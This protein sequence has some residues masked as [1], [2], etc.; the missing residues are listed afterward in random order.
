M[1]SKDDWLPRGMTRADLEAA[2]RAHAEERARLPCVGAGTREERAAR[3]EA[4]GAHKGCSYREAAGGRVVMD[5]DPDCPR[6]R[7]IRAWR[8]RG[9][10]APARLKAT[11]LA[12]L[13]G[14]YDENEDRLLPPVP[15]LETDALKV[16][17]AW[18][19]GKPARV[20][21]A[22]GAAVDVRGDEWCLVLAGPPGCGKS[23]AAAW[24]LAESGAGKWLSATL[25]QSVDLELA[26]YGAPDSDVRRGVAPDGFSAKALLVLDDLGEEHVGASGWAVSRAQHLLCARH[27]D[28]ARTIV[29]TNLRRRGAGQFAERYGERVDDRIN[30]GLFVGLSGPSLRGVR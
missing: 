20:V 8:Q 7:V 28:G 15:L 5:G 29:T 16:A 25:L 21:L 1:T 17:R 14:R 3:C 19:A 27:A 4:A 10:T 2:E 22:G 9:G 12:A 13:P 6:D 11:L 18:A 23:L 30:D 24:A 26:E